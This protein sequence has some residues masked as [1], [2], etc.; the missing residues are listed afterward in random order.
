MQQ[1][2]TA[3]VQKW[4]PSEDGN[5]AKRHEFLN[6]IEQLIHGVDKLKNPEQVNLK[7][8]KNRDGL[9]YETLVSESR[10]PDSGMPMKE[11]NEDL[12]KLLH[13]HPYHSKYF[14]TNILP[15]ASIPGILGMLA[16]FMVNGNNLWD[17]YG[18]AGAE[19]EVKVTAMMSKLAGY[20]AEKSGGYTTWGGQGAVYSGLRI[21]IAKMAPSSLKEGVPANF[22]AF[23]SEAA[24]YSLYKSMEAAGLGSDHL[25]KV[26]T[27]PDHSM[28]TEDLRQ[29]LRQVYENGGVPVYIVATTGT[30]DA[31]GIDDVSAVRLAAEETAGEFG[32]QVPHIHADSALGG[33]FAFFNEYDLGENALSFSPGVIRMIKAIQR[34]MRHLHAADSLCFD[35]Q[36][37]G[38]T[39]YVT[40][41]FLVKD[42]ADLK[43]V[44]LDPD[45]TPYVGHRGYGDY[46]TG[47]TLEC[48]RMASSI[49]MYS[50]LMA[51]GIEGYQK[52]IGQFLE[53]NLHFREQL[54]R[55]IPEAEIMNPDNCGM[56]TLFRIY[57]EGAPR[58]AEEIAG[59][60]TVEELKR[61]NAL[62]EK[63][64]EKLGAK[65]EKMFFGDTKKH[66]LVGTRE[67]LEVPLSV[68]KFFVIS[69][70]TKLEHVPEIIDYLKENVAEVCREY[71]SLAAY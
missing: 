15:M 4:F 67:G 3:D 10:I 18:P 31:I 69:P 33:F 70:Y 8:E 60:C 45:E 12:L 20:D 16:A 40:S 50:A 65:R 28:D 37:L 63:L 36:K 9:F 2:S 49:S 54:A 53:V 44:D 42:A 19:A 51:F 61:N 6:L 41:L 11:V 62:N 59:E 56:S 58:R 68:S 66:L 39:P 47:Y 13:G 32:M 30:T 5:E 57:P 52:L 27:H 24:H 7:G 35:F 14:F 48:S 1:P 43:R 25:I 34:K 26:K 22:Y 55:R 21:A 23:C 17:V 38:Q 64:F 71:G 29:K 46:H